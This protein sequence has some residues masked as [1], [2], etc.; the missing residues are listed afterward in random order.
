[1]III[2]YIKRKIKNYYIGTCGRKY[3]EFPP[4]PPPVENRHFDQTNENRVKA[5]LECNRETITPHQYA[6]VSRLDSN[7][8]LIKPIRA[9]DVTNIIK[10]FKTKAPG[11]SGINKLILSSLPANAIERYSLTTN[12]TLSMGHY[13][14]TYKNGLLIFTPKQGRDPRLPKNYRPITLLKVSGKILERII[15]DRFMYFCEHNDILSK[16]QFGFRKRKGTDTAIAIAYEKIS[17]NQQHKNHCNVVCRD[18][19]KAFDRVWI[20]G[21][22]YKIIIQNKLPILIKK[23]ICSFTNGRTAQIRINSIIGPKFQLKSGVPQGNILSPS[24]F[25]FYTHDLPLLQSDLSTDVIFADDVTQVVEYKGNDRE[26]LAIQF[27]QE[28][29][30]VNEFKKLWKIKTNPTKF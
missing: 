2:K 19:A 7:N 1:M 16:N 3:F 6:D 10:K 9:S 27:E 5:F 8:I 20:E 15:N 13:P 28:I 17:V 23:I 4:P 25:I 26:Q 12:L 22:Q 11:I 21:L 14:Y 30:R 24:L 29:L 18:V